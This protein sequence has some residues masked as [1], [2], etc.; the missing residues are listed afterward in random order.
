MA[1]TC[2]IPRDRD[3]EQDLVTRSSE[4]VKGKKNALHADVRHYR[5]EPVNGENKQF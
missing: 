3:L 2:E 4:Q 1:A 5:S